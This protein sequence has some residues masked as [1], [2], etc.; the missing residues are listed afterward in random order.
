MNISSTTDNCGISNL[1]SIMYTLHDGI[2]EDEVRQY[3]FDAFKKGEN[4]YNKLIIFSDNDEGVTGKKLAK[5]IQFKLKYGRVCC[6]GPMVKN[7]ARFIKAYIWAPNDKFWEDIE[8][9]NGVKKK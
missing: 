3:L 2:T 4:R 1:N 8:K 7:Y 9:A 6:H 5:L